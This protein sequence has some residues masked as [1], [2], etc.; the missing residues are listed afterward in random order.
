MP[1]LKY[2]L[3]VQTNKNTF[4]NTDMGKNIITFLP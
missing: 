3:N 2:L 4:K 1:Q